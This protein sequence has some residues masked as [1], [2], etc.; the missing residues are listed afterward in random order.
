[1]YFLHDEEYP[2]STHIIRFNPDTLPSLS[3]PGNCSWQNDFSS[4]NEPNYSI[5][6]NPYPD[7]DITEMPDFPDACLKF[8]NDILMEEDLDNSSAS[9]QDHDALQ[10]TEKSLYDA[11]GET[12]PPSSDQCQSW[13]GQST[14]ICDDLDRIQSS[15]PGNSY[16]DSSLNVVE[17]NWLINQS[18]LESFQSFD[19]TPQ[20]LESTSQCCGSSS[21]F[22][23]MR[24]GLADS[25]V[26]TLGEA[27]KY[28]PKSNYSSN[29][30]AKS[31][32]NQVYKESEKLVNGS[33]ERKYHHR[34]NSLDLE[35]RSSKQLAANHEEYVEMEKFDD[36]LIC[37]EG[38]DDI[39]PCV[40]KSSVDENLQQKGNSRGSK[41]KSKTRGKKKSNKGQ[42]VDLR[43]LLTQCAQSVASFELTNAN[44]LLKQIR[45]HASPT[46]DSVQR[47]AHYFSNGIEARLA[48]TG[49]D[50]YKGLVGRHI[51]SY[52]ILKGYKL[53]VSAIPFQRT[54]YFLANQTIAK[55]AEKATRIHII[56]F[57]IF[58]GFQW[59]GLIQ[60]LSRRPLGPPKLRITG[61]DYPTSGFKPA[62]KVEETGRRLEGYCKRFGVPFE[63]RAIAQRWHALR[64]ED[65]KI[66]RDE[67]V[68]VTCL[69]QSRKLPDESV[70]VNSP[71]DY[72]MRMIRSLNPDLFIHGVVNGTFNAPFF[73]TRFREALYHYSCLFDVFDATVP[74]EDNERMSIEKLLYGKDVVNIVA[75]EGSE[76]IER[77]ETYNQW[78]VRQQRAGFKQ[79]RLDQDIVNRARAIVKA[80]YHKDFM[81]EQERDWMVQ[82]WKGRTLSAISCWK[83]A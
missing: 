58:F 76:R 24:D 36:V 61:V 42:V 68:V 64:S 29:P 39:S 78:Q 41:S 71:R 28:M 32:M 35:E 18:Q 67:L 46:G 73:I 55:L 69:Y 37:K 5:Y 9:L 19:G 34:E 57:G 83:P 17:S 23:H 33:R 38:N 4:S 13:V 45:Q 47:V 51:S 77:P 53:Y 59:P 79:V 62:Q 49:S 72:F 27:C 63:F 54:S 26:S 80:N 31:R 2:E 7:G 66:E 15:Q 56:D 10:A 14:E 40:R 74:R 12:Y 11:L 25:P 65:F 52:D 6:Q 60:N 1:M 30:K 82:G 3:A 8:I 43:A 21:S 48:G 70:D 16:Y 44:E 22:D 75:C 20:T 50:S 81:V